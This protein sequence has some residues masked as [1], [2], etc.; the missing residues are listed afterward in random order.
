MAQSKWTLWLF[1]SLHKCQ[2]VMAMFILPN[3]CYKFFDAPVMPIIECQVRES[4][5]FNL[6]YVYLLMAFL[7]VFIGNCC[8]WKHLRMECMQI[9]T[10]GEGRSINGHRQK[11]PSSEWLFVFPSRGSGDNNLSFLEKAAL[12][13]TRLP[14]KVTRP[15][16]SQRIHPKSAFYCNHSAPIP[17]KAPWELV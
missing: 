4:Q 6:H 14:K 12:K 10:M 13:N 11:R 5:K 16:R 15:G 9:Q 17:K 1:S 7:A 8:V 2:N 3:G